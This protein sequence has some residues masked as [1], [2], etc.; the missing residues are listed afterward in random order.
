MNDKM[1]TV[2]INNQSYTAKQGSTILEIINQNE[3]PHPQVCYVPEVIR[4][5]PAIPVSSKS[6]EC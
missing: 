1:I 2:K 6:M 3:I 4:F 5:K